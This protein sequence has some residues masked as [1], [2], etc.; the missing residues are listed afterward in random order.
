MLIAAGMGLRMY[1]GGFGM[2][3]ECLHRLR[4]ERAC[5]TLSS[6]LTTEIMIARVLEHL[7]LVTSGD[8]A[9]VPHI[10]RIRL[11]LFG[12]WMI[13]QSRLWA[14]NISYVA[15]HGLG[16]HGSSTA[17][18]QAPVHT[19]SVATVLTRRVFIV[20]GHSGWLAALCCSTQETRIGGRTSPRI[21]DPW[22]G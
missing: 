2:P 6:T 11:D 10:Y 9:P 7:L 19:W 12:H 13:P 1:A 21:E 17:V 20:S 14:D 22:A 18:R 16:P 5:A 8:F 3:V 4:G 15:E